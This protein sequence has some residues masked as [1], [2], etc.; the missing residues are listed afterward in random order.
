MFCDGTKCKKGAAKTSHD[1]IQFC[2]VPVFLKLGVAT[3]LC[4]AKILQCD[5]KKSLLQRSHLFSHE[6]FFIKNIFNLLSITILIVNVTILSLS[7]SDH[8]KWIQ[9]YFLG[10]LVYL[11]CL[12]IRL[13]QTKFLK[14][15]SLK[16]VENHPYS[17]PKTILKQFYFAMKYYY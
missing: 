10:V 8:I 6:F 17:R 1:F 16:K 5:A 3:H 12:C 13:S 4:V 11:F 2:R 9:L 14:F 15:C 7:Q